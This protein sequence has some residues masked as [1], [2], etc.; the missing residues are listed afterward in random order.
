MVASTTAS[1]E[2]KTWIYAFVV[3]LLVSVWMLTTRLL[4]SSFLALDFEIALIYLPTVLAG[5]I[6]VYVTMKRAK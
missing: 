6:A 2:K 1:D 5:I 3:L 4:Q